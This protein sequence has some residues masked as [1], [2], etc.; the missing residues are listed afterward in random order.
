M[1]GCKITC[2][3]DCDECSQRDPTG[4]CGKYDRFC[5]QIHIDIIKEDGEE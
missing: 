2:Y 4:W 5:G 1:D 3:Y